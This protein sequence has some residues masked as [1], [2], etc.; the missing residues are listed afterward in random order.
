MADRMVFIKT[1]LTGGGAGALDA[2]D[3]AN[4]GDTNPL[5]DGDAAFVMASGSLY[6]YLGDIDSAL[7]ESSPGV[8]RPDTN[9]G[10]FRWIQQGASVTIADASI[11]LAKLANM[12]T[13][14]LYYRKTG[15]NGAPEV[16]TL[17]TLKTDL[18]LTGTNSGDNS[19]ATEG[20]AG[21]VELA[22][23]AETVTGTA[24]DR[25]VT[26]A[27]LTAHL[28]SPKPIGETAP[29]TIRGKNK[30]IYKTASADSPLTAT[31]CSGTIVSNYGMTDADCIIDLPT[32]AEG[33]AFVCILPA[34]QARYFRLRCPSAEA[35]KI[36]L[37]GVAGSDDGYVGVASGYTT[38]ASASF[39][40]FKA[41]D[42]NYD[43]MCVPI[44]GTWVAGVSDFGISK[45]DKT[46]LRDIPAISV[47]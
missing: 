37:L 31:E 6:A 45:I 41:S 33:L 8:I 1:A 35:D 18:G 28:A 2:V 27:N 29:N 44:F 25:A 16:N 17:A 14:S 39:F 13:A 4:R 43:W 38:G 21:I 26:P 3:G 30:E 12:A 19:A 10:D 34:V 42:G 40:T 7:P 36:Y 23:D 46:T 5:Q 15:G 9:A 20:A 24:T 47:V 22:T 11:T 32:A